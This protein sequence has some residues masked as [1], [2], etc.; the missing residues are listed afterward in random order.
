MPPQAGGGRVGRAAARRQHD[1]E[2]N[3]RGKLHTARMR[4]FEGRVKD[5]H[6]EQLR[7]EPC[8]RA[9]RCARAPED[10]KASLGTSKVAEQLSFSAS[11]S[12]AHVHRRAPNPSCPRTP[13]HTR[14]GWALG[15]EGARSQPP[16]PAERKGRGRAQGPGVGGW[17]GLSLRPHSSSP[18]RRGRTGH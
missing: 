18:G 3:R 14:P 10:T 16:S 9:G 7:H 4:G 8:G 1:P 12:C 13:G 6:T 11:H 5:G 17:R 2:G 15:T